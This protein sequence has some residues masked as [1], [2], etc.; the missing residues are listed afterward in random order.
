MKVMFLELNEFNLQLL[1]KT[2]RCFHLPHVQ[3]LL[4]MYQSQ[5]VTQDSYESDFLEPW[6]QWVSVHTGKPS[7]IHQIKHLGDVPHLDTEQI[8]ELLSQR[9]LTSGIW[10]AMNATRGTAT[11]CL[12]FLPDP[13]T[14]SEKAYPEELNQLL[15][16]LRFS[17]KN[18][19]GNVATHIAGQLKGMIKLI[20]SYG[21]GK[22][23][24][25]QIPWLLK[26]L[27]RFKGAH[28]VFIAFAE[29]LSTSLFLAFK[30]KFNPDFS[31]LFINLLAHLQHHY[32]TGFDYEKNQKLECGLKVL[33][34][35][36]GKIF[37]SLEKEDL[38]LAANA[39]SQKNTNDEKPW[40][41]YRPL[42]H[43]RFLNCV[44]IFP[45]KIEPLMT[46]DA[47]L[48]FETEKECQRAVNLL[49]SAL[50]NG[51]HLFLVETYP[52]FPNKLFY[53]I[54]FTDKV[55]LDTLFSVHNKTLRFFDYYKGIVQR[56]GKHIPLGTIF[57]NLDKL[58][59]KLFNHE[60]FDLIANVSEALCLQEQTK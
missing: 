44:G 43:Q 10:G 33:D 27:I 16:P 6:V 48:F 28:F 54:D 13:W 25:K 31:L 36:L 47:H 39:L 56:T 30:K 23:I 26:N 1:Q 24:A 34:K 4:G 8:W 41:L 35:I 22:E 60:I 11:H 29:Y 55:S 46:H 58:P 12:F 21:L 18:Y 5:T 53:R 32:W 15:D 3:K 38:F 20:R 52:E 45:S 57:C 37:A 49:K 40:I 59:P 19:L 9:G 2:S 42:D 14:A 17:S 50:I 7:S 51:K